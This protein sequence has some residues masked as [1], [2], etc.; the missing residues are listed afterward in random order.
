[1]ITFDGGNVLDITDN[2]DSVQIAD[3]LTFLET[4]TSSG[5]FTNEDD[6]Q[7]A[8]LFVKKDAPRNT[9]A[10]INYDDEQT[11]LVVKNFTASVNFDE[12]AVGEE[13]NSGEILPILMVD[14]DHNLNSHD[15]ED[16]KFSEEDHVYPTIH[17]G[18][19]LLLTGN[20]SGNINVE[21]AGAASDTATVDGSSG[22][23]YIGSGATG[24]GGDLDVGGTTTSV[25]YTHLTLPT[26][27]LV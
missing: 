17:V 14:E 27:L 7:D 19:P 10:I 4:S 12:S 26:I 22:V 3:H 2:D 21:L 9:T 20:S 11:S 8:N 6:D 25:S 13:W 1:M 16:F 23:G 24:E 5:I 15:D 18:D